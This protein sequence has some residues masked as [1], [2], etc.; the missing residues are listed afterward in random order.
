[1]IRGR[2]HSAG[3]ADDPRRLDEVRPRERPQATGR[4]Q[5][6]R[7]QHQTDTGGEA[8]PITQYRSFGVTLDYPAVTSDG[9][10]I[11]FHPRR[12]G[13]LYLHPQTAARST[14]VGAVLEVADS[15][16]SLSHDDERRQ[17]LRPDGKRS[18]PEESLASPTIIDGL[19]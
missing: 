10:K 18:E 15:L 12:E 5:H 16:D 14:A 19:V 2:R 8:K 1:M 6:N 3:L 7:A 17:S 11:F 4:D 13:R 9:R